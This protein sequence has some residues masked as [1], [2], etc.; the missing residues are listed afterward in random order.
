[1][2]IILINIATGHRV[3]EYSATSVPRKDEVVIFQEGDAETEMLVN[4]A[5]HR[6]PKDGDAW[7]E[8]FCRKL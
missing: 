3:Y 5:V 8:V 2:K 6:I 7:A 4:Q 1:M